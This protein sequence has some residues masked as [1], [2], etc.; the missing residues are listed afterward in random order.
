MTLGEDDPQARVLHP[1]LDRDRPGDRHV[2]AEEAGPEITDAEADRMEEE[3]SCK[4]RENPLLE[5]EVI[6]VEEER[7]QCNM[8][9]A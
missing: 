8:K 6:V 3:K 7:H 2:V 5:K 9:I 1:H 4:F